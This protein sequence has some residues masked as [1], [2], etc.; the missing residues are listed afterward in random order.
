VLVGCAD[1]GTQKST[2]FVT[3]ESKDGSLK[4]IIREGENENSVFL[5]IGSTGS[6]DPIATKE[7]IIPR[8]YH[9]P[10]ISMLWKNSRILVIEID[11]D[12]GDGNQVY[13]YHADTGVLN[14]LK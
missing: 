6:N 7:I 12:F 4:A 10:V 3:S 2:V 5:S 13:E 11:H 1:N 8:S 14:K 9:T